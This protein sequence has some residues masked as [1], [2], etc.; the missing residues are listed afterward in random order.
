[1]I[2]ADAWNKKKD[3]TARTEYKK[4]IEIAKSCLFDYN[5]RIKSKEDL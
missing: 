5:N 4:H 2:L 3:A 1:M